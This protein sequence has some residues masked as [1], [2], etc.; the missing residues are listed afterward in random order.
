MLHWFNEHEDADVIWLWI[1]QYNRKK[2]TSDKTEIKDREVVPVEKQV[3][4]LDYLAR[5]P[6]GNCEL[7][8]KFIWKSHA[9]QHYNTPSPREQKPVLICPVNAQAATLHASNA[10]KVY[11]L[12]RKGNYTDGRPLYRADEW[13]YLIAEEARVLTGSSVCTLK[14][15]GVD[16][17]RVNPAFRQNEYRVE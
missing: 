8:N 9:D 10:K 13:G 4:S 1:A 14:I 12:Q 16:Y 2:N 6:K 3:I 7:P 11:T 15:N 17:G 5:Y